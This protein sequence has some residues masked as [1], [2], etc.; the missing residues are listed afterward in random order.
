MMEPFEGPDEVYARITEGGRHVWSAD[1][2]GA[3]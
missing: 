1:E 3:A 2:D